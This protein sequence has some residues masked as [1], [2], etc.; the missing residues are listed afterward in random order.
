[1]SGFQRSRE[2]M[3][4]RL[5]ELRRSAQLT[6]RQLA[7]RLS[8]HPSKI[9]KI[10]SGRQTATEAD[11]RVWAQACEAAEA[12]PDLLA[13]LRVIDDQYIEFRRM[14]RAGQRAK[15]E[16]IGRLEDDVDIVRNFEPAF[17]PGLLQTPAYARVRLAEG[18][19]LIGAPDDVDAAV[20]ARIQRQQA[21]YR[22]GRR[23]HFVITE[24]VLRYRLCPPDVLA[25][26]LDRLV[27][28]TTLQTLRLGVIPFDQPLPI[29]PVHGFHLHGERVVFVEHLTGE[30]KL[31][32][33]EELRTYLA[34]FARLG[35]VARYG[36]QARALIVAALEDLS[37]GGSGG[38]GPGN[39]PGQGNVPDAQNSQ[40]R[41]ES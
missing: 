40:P 8:W 34:V 32:Q 9:S 14:F 31:T 22:P 7:E 24:A 26:Q 16:E 38:S 4:S 12:L 29:A 23:H 3:G 6:G 27:A 10:E 30:L 25:E 5:R 37:V 41:P 2:A 36:A 13:G 35:S 33:P 21:L 28:A 15:Q 20:A 11:V 19:D 18:L 39:I 17:I 1:M